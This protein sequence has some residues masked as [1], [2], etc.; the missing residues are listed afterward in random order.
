MNR[1]LMPSAPS[2][3]REPAGTPAARRG[4]ESEAS[5]PARVRAGSNLPRVG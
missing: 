1:A 3:D 2:R 5:W 4:P